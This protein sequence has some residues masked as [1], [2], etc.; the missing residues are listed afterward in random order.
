MPKNSC[1]KRTVRVR[2]CSC[3]QAAPKAKTS[4]ARVGKKWPAS[5][6]AGI[7]KCRAEG[8][9]QSTCMREAQRCI[10]SRGKHKGIFSPGARPVT[11]VGHSRIGVSGVRSRRRKSR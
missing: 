9:D 10:K 4:T 5:C 6:R 1:R 8:I 7:K 3:S 2:R 11:D